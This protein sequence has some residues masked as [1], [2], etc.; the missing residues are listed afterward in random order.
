MP[1]ATSVTTI[2]DLQ[3]DGRAQTSTGNLL[4]ENYWGLARYL[5]R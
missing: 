5:S 4:G 1:I 3:P 2:F